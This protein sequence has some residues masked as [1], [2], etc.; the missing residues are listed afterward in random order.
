MS[1]Q[2]EV[3]LDLSRNE[4]EHTTW[5]TS[6]SVKPQTRGMS[7]RAYSLI[8]VYHSCQLPS[9]ASMTR[10]HSDRETHALS[11]S[12]LSRWDL[13]NRKVIHSTMIVSNKSDHHRTHP[14]EVAYS[15]S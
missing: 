10:D 6:A 3:Q 2:M 12:V 15:R 4:I 7:T 5:R 9:I 13:R 11:G 8:K 1:T 14:M